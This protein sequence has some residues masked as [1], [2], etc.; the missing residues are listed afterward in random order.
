MRREDAARRVSTAAV[1]ALVL[2]APSL[3]AQ[4]IEPRSYSNAPVGVNFA[5]AGIAFTRGAL[6]F[7]AETFLT[8][9]KINTRSVVLAY[10]HVLDLWGKSAKFDVIL[11]YMSLSGNALFAGAPVERN[12]D[13]PVD[14]RFR[15]SVNLYGAPAMGL[16]DFRNYKQDLI[17]GASLQVT[18]PVGQYDR[19]RLV[20]IGAN[21]WSF[22]PEL[23]VSK[24]VGSWTVEGKLAAIFF[25][26][27]D[28]FFVGRRREQDP[29]ASLQGNVIY[30]FANGVW[31]SF[32]G[33]YYSG[34]RTTLDGVRGADLQQNSRLG[35]T[36]AVPLDRRN[37]VKLYASSGV[38][39]R[40]GNNFDLFGI[41]WQHRWGGGL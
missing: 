18:A 7:P 8:D 34:G 9:A 1:A 35:A 21:R 14:P 10:A 17:V 3:R 13:G 19:M 36:L 20:N 16:Q 29:I 23:G 12:V 5:I 22:K 6:E 25:T 38:H 37:S 30:G 24:A 11:P 4:E 26:T 40:T 31:V 41:A 15:L 27:N 39:A 28:D 32:D 33:T 2:A